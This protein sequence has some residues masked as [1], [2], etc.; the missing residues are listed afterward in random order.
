MRLVSLCH[1][2]LPSHH[3]NT[4]QLVWTMTEL[5]QLGHDVDVVFS[6]SDLC[7]RS[8]IKAGIPE[9]RVTTNYNGYSP[10]H[11]APALTREAARAR[12]GLGERDRIATY[13][14]H[15]DIS[16]GIAFLVRVAQQMPDVI[17]LLVGAAPG[18]DEEE[19]LGSL[20]RTTGAR[21]IRPLPRVRQA[22]SS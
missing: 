19:T 22:E 4:Q 1:H 12:L 5:A 8:F 18:S 3:T 14:G 17:F 2:S 11:F 6:N 21:T 15:V 20:I 13:T 16:K 10:T 7:R 9:A